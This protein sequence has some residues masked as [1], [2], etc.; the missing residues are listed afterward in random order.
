MRGLLLK[1]FYMMGKYCRTYL[2]LLV[3]FMAVSIVG[4]RSLF[5]IIYPCTL[6]GMIPVTLLSYDEQSRWSEYCGTLPC[7]KAQIVSAKYLIGL[8]AQL[9]VLILLGVCQAVRMCM[10]GVWEAGGY[11]TLMAVLMFAACAA[12]SACLPFMFRFG[13]EKGRIAYYLIVGAASAGSLI[14]GDFFGQ[15]VQTA[16][17]VLS[18]GTVIALFA[19]EAALYAVSWYLSIVFYQKREGRSLRNLHRLT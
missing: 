5:F 18:A 12:S 19:A 1:D 17:P 7:S 6:A 10:G 11:L 9:A 16:A 2:L 14:A 15:D 8:L 13:V 3:F 4:S